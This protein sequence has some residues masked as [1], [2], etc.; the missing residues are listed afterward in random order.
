M[1]A[2][3]LWNYFLTEKIAKTHPF[4]RDFLWVKKERFE[5]V[6][7]FFKEECNSLHRGKSYRSNSFFKHI[8]AVDQGNCFF[9]HFDCGN[10]KKFLPLILVHYLADVIPFF[11]FCLLKRK[12]PNSFYRLK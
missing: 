10:H 4:D 1:D 6:K 5:K 8:H 2:K 3:Q 11:A 12:R 9:V 7:K